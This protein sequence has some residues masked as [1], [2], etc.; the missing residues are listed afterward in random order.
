MATRA[1]RSDRTLLGVDYD[2]I[3][4]AVV[5]SVNLVPLVGVLFWGWSLGAVVVLYWIENAVIGLTNVPKLILAS[6]SD[7]EDDADDAGSV[8]LVF[9]VPFFLFHYGMFWTVH[10]VFVFVL[11]VPSI[12][13]LLA[14]WDTLLLAV[15]S[16]VVQHAV[17]FYREF[18]RK[19]RYL[20]RAVGDQLTNP[21]G[22]VV[23]LHVAIIGGGFVIAA[24]G[25][26]LGGLVLLVV[27]KTGYD[28]GV[29]FVDQREDDS[30]VTGRMRT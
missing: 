11:F 29:W 14:L 4:L 24:A 5:V 12:P 9:F 15:V 30:G 13:E 10:G 28:L 2:L 20:D 21:Y 25:T 8:M 23:V 3:D 27:L 16:L 7:G 19:R 18:Y 22:R 17:G 6:R 26:P 1:D